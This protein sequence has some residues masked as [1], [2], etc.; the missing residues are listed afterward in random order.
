MIL[1]NNVR[2]LYFDV[3]SHSYDALI[4]QLEIKQA[5]ELC[6]VFVTW[7]VFHEIHTE[8]DLKN[9][10]MPSL[11]L[12]NCTSIVCFCEVP[13][14]FCPDG[15]SRDFI[16]AV[17][18]LLLHHGFSLCKGL[19]V[20]TLYFPAVHRTLHRSIRKSQ[21]TVLWC[22]R[23]LFSASNNMHF[24]FPSNIHIIKHSQVLYKEF[25]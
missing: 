3:S 19:E 16:L 24:Y 9:I 1:A 4:K 11:Y 20:E 23:I 12:N 7:D 2:Q 17:Q 6:I 14:C 25:N 10:Q 13:T 21:V 15:F 18:F 8:I 22:M 5:V